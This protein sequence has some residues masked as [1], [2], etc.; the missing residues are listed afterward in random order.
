METCL[1]CVREAPSSKFGR[2]GFSWFFSAQA[3]VKAKPRPSKSFSVTNFPSHRLL[4]NFTSWNSVVT[5]FF[6]RDD[7]SLCALGR[8]CEWH[9]TARVADLDNVFVLAVR[10]FPGYLCLHF[11]YSLSRIPATGGTALRFGCTYRRRN[12][13]RNTANSFR[14]G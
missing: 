5:M 10:K 9:S 13:L 12:I 8:H 7:R 1:S 14:E 2:E 11:S 4:H 3:N 6:V